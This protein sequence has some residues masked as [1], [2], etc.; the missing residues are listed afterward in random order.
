MKKLKTSEKISI[1]F[2]G[3]LIVVCL[4]VFQCVNPNTVEF[5]F[6]YQWF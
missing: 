1:A 6:I 3:L 5:E 4:T 2:L